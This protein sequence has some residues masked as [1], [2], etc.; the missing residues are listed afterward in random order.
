MSIA[1]DR[2]GMSLNQPAPKQRS[3]PQTRRDQS[4]LASATVATPKPEKQAFIAKAGQL[5]ALTW[6]DFHTTRGLTEGKSCQIK[7][8]EG[9]LSIAEDRVSIAEDPCGMSLNQQ[10]PKHRSK[11]QSRRDP[12]NLASA[13]V[14]TPK[15]GKNRPYWQMPD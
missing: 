13:T 12:P 10:S 5:C 9:I 14:A 15:T 3:N 2:C 1:D 6:K 4:N 11:S 7:V 8:Q